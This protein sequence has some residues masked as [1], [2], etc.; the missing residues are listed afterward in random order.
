MK[1]KY[2]AVIPDSK[3]LDIGENEIIAIFKHRSH[4][5]MFG[6]MFW[7]K[8]FLIKEVYSEVII[9]TISQFK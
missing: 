3:R 6:S 8:F 2:F 5:E 4:A 7:G 9:R 1:N